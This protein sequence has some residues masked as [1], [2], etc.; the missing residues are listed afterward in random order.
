MDWILGGCRVILLFYWYSFLG[1]AVESA[2]CS[3]TGKKLV[4]RGFLNGPVC[5]V[6]GVGALV[7]IYLLYPVQDY[8]VLLYLF[9]TILV[10]V[11]EY[12]TG[13]LLET[14]F[15]ARWWDYSHYRFNLKGRVCLPNALFF[16]VLALFAMKVL[17][18]FSVRILGRLSPVAT[19]VCTGVLSA[20]F[21]AD[22]V[23][24]VRAAIQ[25]SGKLDEMRA[26]LADAR[27]RADAAIQE[28]RLQAALFAAMSPQEKLQALRE[29]HVDS[30]LLDRISR[31]AE[32]QSLLHRR[33]MN[34]FPHMQFPRSPASLETL[35]SEWDRLR[36]ERRAKKQSES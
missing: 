3:S 26:A 27:A 24:S 33:L 10:S 35:R 6:Y 14:L 32:H 17:H 13:W 29:L 25:L 1:W 2:I 9:G 34:A 8:P 11:V 19:F 22:L 36:R 16:G 12:F 4:N 28:G 21:A 30:A 31:L 15:H 5:P 23:L 18:P 7:C 20:V